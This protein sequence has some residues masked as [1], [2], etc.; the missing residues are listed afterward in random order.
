MSVKC[1]PTWTFLT[2]GLVTRNKILI[3]F[4]RDKIELYLLNTRLRNRMVFIKNYLYILNY[5]NY[6]IFLFK[7]KK[8]A[9]TS[10]FTFTHDR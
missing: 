1:P 2:V 7:Q 3:V 4:K 9:I 5:V 6:V 8:I 10:S